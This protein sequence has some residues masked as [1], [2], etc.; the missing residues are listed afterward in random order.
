MSSTRMRYRASAWTFTCQLR[1]KSVKSL[2]YRPP[3]VGLQREVHVVE[4]HLLGLE[5]VAVDLD[6]ELGLVRP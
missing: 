5:L 2:T 1:L 4:R 6:E 3:E